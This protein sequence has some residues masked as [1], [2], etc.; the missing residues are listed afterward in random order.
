[1]LVP[2][3]DNTMF[4]CNP[5]TLC[6]STQPTAVDPNSTLNAAMDTTQLARF[7]FSGKTFDAIPCEIYDGDTLSFVFR[8]NGR[9]EK[10]RCRT[11]G[12]DSPEIKPRLTHPTR[13]REIANAKAAKE[14]FTQ[15]VT[16]QSKLVQIRCGAFDKYGRVLVTIIANGL[17]VNEAMIREGHGYEYHGGTK[18]AIEPSDTPVSEK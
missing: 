4:C 12:Y 6:S 18:R 5:F 11:L 3:I 10:W 15:L 7:T 14:R 13:D 16:T 8:N 9:V 1:M 2:T 17:N